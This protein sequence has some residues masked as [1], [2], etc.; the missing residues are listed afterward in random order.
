[1]EDT[2]NVWY[3]DYG[4]QSF[5]CECARHGPYQPYVLKVSNDDQLKRTF[6]PV[7]RSYQCTFKEIIGL[8][9][10]MVISIWQESLTQERSW[11]GRL[12]I[13]YNGKMKALTTKKKIGHI[14][15]FDDILYVSEGSAKSWWLTWC[16]IKE[17][18]KSFAE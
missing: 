18:E 5:L 14:A 13:H 16:P 9:N 7:P 15:V 2:D 8:P 11:Q 4:T 10:G 12:V 1:M 3:L 17:L 6:L